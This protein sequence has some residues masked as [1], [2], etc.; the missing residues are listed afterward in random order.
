MITSIGLENYKSYKH[1]DNF[2]IKP[3][4]VLCGTNSSGKSSII[5]SILTL[6][7]SF[8]SEQCENFVLFNGNYVNTGMFNTVVTNHDGDTMEFS[9]SFVLDETF[10]SRES[11]YSSDDQSYRL[12]R[13]IYKNVSNYNIDSETY[14]I[15]YTIKLNKYTLHNHSRIDNILD[16]FEV[17]V[18]LNNL[19][20]TFFL[21]RLKDQEREYVVDWNDL[22]NTMG[23]F[24]E[25]KISCT[26]YFSGLKLRNLFTQSQSESVVNVLP[27]IISILQVIND[28]YNNI[29]YIGPLREAPSRRYIFENESNDVGIKG[30]NT[31]FVLANSNFKLFNVLTLDATCDESLLEFNKSNMSFREAVKCWCDYIGIDDLNYNEKDEIISLNVG[32]DN[33]VDV[34]FGVSQTLPIIVEGLLIKKNQTLL[35]EQPEIHLHPRMQMK[36]A[37]FLI[38]MSLMGR[39]I[40]VETHSDH[41]VNRLIRRSIE[42]NV[43][44][45]LSDLSINYI[46]K[47][48]GTSCINPIKI[49]KIK[50][51]VD[52]PVGF[53]D[54]YASENERIID[55]GIKNLT[56]MESD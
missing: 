43:Y 53:F 45:I 22:P 10:R 35:L 15:S 21:Q 2:A 23:K 54:Q 31:P 5:K 44:N 48:N 26:C 18:K 56:E 39:K 37:D 55:A 7:Q 13:R 27:N 3:L 32:E 16:R 52:C 17:S 1:L 9:S 46:E 42:K 20:S 8:S 49:D 36:L 33:I 19:T 14:E 50:G 4:T 24:S 28:Q 11:K 40:I 25:G 47:N 38:A 12:L 6:K 29:S 41:L 51:I 30:E 34:G